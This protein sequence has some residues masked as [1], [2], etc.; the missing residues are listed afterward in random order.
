MG[1]IITIANQKGG[2]G[3]TTTAVNLAASLAMEGQPTLLVDC[4]PQGNATSGLGVEIQPE[5]ATLYHVMIGQATADQAVRPTDLEHLHLLGSDVNLF[6]AEVEL[7]GRAG[8]ERLLGEALASL[9][10]RYRFILLDCPP[11]LGLLTLNAL[12]AC[13]GVLVPLQTEYYALEGLTQLLHTI[14]RV[15]R[16]LNPAMRLEGILLTMFDQRN[17]LSHQ[18]SEDVRGH[19]KDMVYDTVV[20]RNVR[21]SEAPSHGLPVLLYDPRCAGAQS[22]EQLAQEVMA[23]PRGNSGAPAEGRAA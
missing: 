11:S 20:P 8:R 18:V 23:G 3:K 14:A 5:N 12:T 22:Y 6:G 1:R 2:V 17:N 13:Q 7:A 10:G 16:T 4:D 21:L 9:A 15:R 19:F